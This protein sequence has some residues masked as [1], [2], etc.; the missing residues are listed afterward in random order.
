MRESLVPSE[1]RVRPRS[2]F[3]DVTPT[4][5]AGFLFPA[6]AGLLFGYDIGAASGALLSLQ[7]SALSSASPL[8]SSVLHSA[9]LVGAVLGTLATFGVAS[10]L[11]RRR[12]MQLGALLYACGSAITIVSYA[13]FIMPS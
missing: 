12:E 13:L 5:F 9:S 2:A 8:L 6:L 1:E 4:V 7:A 10:A 11:G 3:G